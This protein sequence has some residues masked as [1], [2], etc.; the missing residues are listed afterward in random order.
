VI[1]ARRPPAVAPP[2]IVRDPDLVAG[3][4]EDASGAAPGYAAGVVR[5]ESESEASALL[6]STLA[7][8][9]AILCQAARTSLTAGAIPRGEIVVSVERM[10]AIGPV[11]RRPGGGRV[12]VEPGVRL[13]D[14]RHALALHD[15]Y[16]PPVPTYEQ[17]MVGGTVST[18]AGGAATFKYGV[19]RAWVRALSVVLFNGDVIDVE[20]GQEMARPGEELRV[21]LSSGVELRIPVPRYR[22]PAVKKVS[23]GYHAADPLDLVDLFVGAEGTLG[24]ITSITLDLVPAPPALVTALVFVADFGRAI[25]L[26]GDLRSAALA[27]RAAGDG[28][29]PDVRSIEAVD[30]G[31]LA[32]LC[33]SGDTRRLRVA[34]PDRAGAVVLIEVELKERSTADA[35]EEA[36]LAAY[37]GKAGD[38]P[39]ARLVGILRQYAAL[40]DVQFALPGD[41]T[42]RAALRELREAVPRRVGELLAER[43]RT[44]AGLRKVAGD[45]VVPFDR[46]SEIV[47]VYETGFESRGLAY[48]IW[49]HLS[50]GNLHPNALVR[51]E[52]EVAA[53]IDAL[54]EFADA[55]VRLGGSPLSEHGVGRDPVKQRM[56]RRFLGAE[57]IDEMRAIK[58]ALDPEGRFAPGV[59]FETATAPGPTP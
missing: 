37:D 25:G 32:L 54:D 40:D 55:A 19:T 20:R 15:L 48:A 8:G 9:E 14:F 28:R 49:G 59:L 31:G 22:L 58:R 56:L 51:D 13:D 18:N 4:L 1:A 44:S 42:R 38:T 29:G 53:A 24:L 43:Q 7:S 30:G 3:Y 46:V 50:D 57:A 33:A 35:A 17:A 26:A 21:R 6:S 41:E 5:V 45:L 34:V 12:V 16:Y 2:G 47:R 39:L 11:E 27:S 36:L 10:G 23:A 52:R